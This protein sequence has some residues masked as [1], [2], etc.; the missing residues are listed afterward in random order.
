[1]SKRRSPWGVGSEEPDLPGDDHRPS[2]VP[3]PREIK[4]QETQLK[5]KHKHDN[6][7]AVKVKMAYK[8]G[9]KEAKEKRG[10]K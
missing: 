2:G 8:T 5:S 4:S 9:A 3:Q 7:K 10:S 6:S 1:L